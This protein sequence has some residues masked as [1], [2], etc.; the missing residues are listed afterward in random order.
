MVTAVICERMGW[1]YE[2]YLAQPLWFIDLLIKKYEIDSK[3]KP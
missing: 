3:S 1:G 2:T